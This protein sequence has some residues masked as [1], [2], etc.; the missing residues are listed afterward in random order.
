MCIGKW[1]HFVG[2]FL[3]IDWVRVVCVCVCL[4]KGKWKGRQSSIW[5][6]RGQKQTFQ[7]QL[8]WE[9]IFS[10]HLAQFWMEINELPSNIRLHFIPPL[11]TL[12][13]FSN[14]GLWLFYCSPDMN[15]HF[16]FAHLNCCSPQ[17][18]NPCAKPH[19]ST[20]VHTCM[21]CVCVCSIHLW[22]ILNRMALPI[23]AKSFGVWSATHRVTPHINV[24]FRFDWQRRFLK[25]PHNALDLFCPNERW[26]SAD[27]SRA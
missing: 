1:Y 13:I 20:S 10:P 6:I 11:H 7:S 15:E 14:V 24:V 23:I 16:L 21:M 5:R 8:N 4:W 3:S 12:L 26:K 18:H 19:N 9:I 17:V 22:S 25:T 2:N 27:H